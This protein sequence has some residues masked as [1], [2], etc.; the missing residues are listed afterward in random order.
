MTNEQL[1]EL[2][3]VGGNDELLPLLWDKTRVLIFKKCGTIWRFYSEKLTRCGCTL[4]DLRQEAYS[5]LLLAVKGYKAEKG[6]KFTT[7]LSYALKRIVRGLLSGSDVLNQASTE[8]LSQ[9]IGTDK[10]GEPLLVEDVVAD[11]TA[12]AELE[13]I[14]RLD[15]YKVLYEALDHLPA[16]LNEVITEHYFKGMTLK[17]IGE[18]HGFTTERARQ[19]E[20][21]ALKELRRNGKIIAAYR[22]EYSCHSERSSYWKHKGLSAFLSSGSSEV[23]DYVMRRLYLSDLLGRPSNL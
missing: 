21:E 15:E 2:I 4:D 11:D 5:A 12:A 3:Q 18:L 14:E 22:D 6:Y 16:K 19:I 9:P 23:E 1:A 20:T 13:K 7:Y 8:S 10:D 17:Q